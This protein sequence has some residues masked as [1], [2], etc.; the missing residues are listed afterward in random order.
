MFGESKK[1]GMHP[2][3][4]QARHRGAGGALSCFCLDH[5]IACR[6]IRWRRTV[7]VPTRVVCYLAEVRHRNRLNARNGFADNLQ[8][9]SHLEASCIHECTSYCTCYTTTVGCG[10]TAFFSPHLAPCPA[11]APKPAPCP[12]PFRACSRMPS[13]ETPV[14]IDHITPHTTRAGRPKPGHCTIA[15][16]RQD[17][18]TRRARSRS[19]TL[20][21]TPCY[22]TFG[23][24]QARHS[25]KQ[26][27]HGHSSRGEEANTQGLHCVAAGAG[28]RGRVNDGRPREPL[29]ILLLL[30]FLSSS[31]CPIGARQAC[32]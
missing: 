30:C 24:I 9:R 21:H 20:Y 1:N 25:E 28:G 16:P 27:K 10:T 23:T 32:V 31:S 29:D 2:V 18:P 7:N 13:A 3:Q 4:V 17:K 22:L 19:G 12:S 11:L 15:P 26:A 5:L 6:D 8:R 14:T